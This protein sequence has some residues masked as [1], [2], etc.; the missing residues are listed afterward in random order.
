MKVRELDKS[1]LEKL[2]RAQKNEI[3]EH[4][5]YKRLSASEKN[6]DSSR[7]LDEIAGDELK[8]YGIWKSYTGRD[9][10]PYRWKIWMYYL[11]S[12]LF[13]ITFT[14][15]LMESG[16]AQAQIN[17]MEIAR[18]IPDAEPI[19]LDEDRHEEELI[20]LLD[21]ERL[22]YVGAIIRGLNEALIELS[23]ALSGLTLALHESQLIALTGVVTGLALGATE[24]LASKH[25]E[26]ANPL[27][28]AF[29]TS[30]AN[31][32]T[33]ALLIMPFFVFRDYYIALAVMLSIS[34]LIILVF[35][36]HVSVA[37]E[38]NFGKSFTQM[39]VLFIG[40]SALTFLIGYI[41]REVFHISVH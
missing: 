27:K 33:V 36:Y 40:V 8:H 29:Y 12:R 3:T 18:S 14:I 22:R 34:A 41:A 37:K 35:N 17:Y 10:G 32:I 39:L 20:A 24:Y 15:K 13:G 9:L 26:H 2:E 16:E 28:A 21:E 6:A 4:F 19:A 31:F 7:I 11:M 23:A 5:I 30:G 25:E 1:K 38:L